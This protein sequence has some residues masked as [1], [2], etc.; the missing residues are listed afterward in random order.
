VPE[1]GIE[2]TRGGEPHGILGASSAISETALISAEILVVSDLA[3][4]QRNTGSGP[5]YEAG[6]IEWDNSWD[7]ASNTAF[8]RT[9]IP[10]KSC[11]TRRLIYGGVGSCRYRDVKRDN[12]FTQFRPRAGSAARVDRS[13]LTL[14]SCNV[15]PSLRAS[16]RP[17]SGAAVVRHPPL[18]PAAEARS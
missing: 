14:G 16:R 13:R 11:F 5:E 2:P 12:H 10:S 4:G 8:L 15:D 17:P 18:S 6:E 9:I 7:S 3:V 1:E